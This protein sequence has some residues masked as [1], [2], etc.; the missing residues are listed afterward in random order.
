[1]TEESIP[2]DNGEQTLVAFLD[3][4]PPCIVR[5]VARRP[6]HHGQRMSL[7]EIAKASG[8]SYGTVLRLS[9]KRTWANVPPDR[10]DKFCKACR[11]DIVKPSRAHGLNA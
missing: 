8:L 9:L 10:I 7:H 4:I 1:M 2:A 6:N 11:V 5:L 3:R